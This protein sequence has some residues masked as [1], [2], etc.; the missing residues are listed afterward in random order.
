MTTPSISFYHPLSSQIINFTPGFSDA[1]TTRNLQTLFNRSLRGVKYRVKE[2]QLHKVEGLWDRIVYFFNR[3]AEQAKVKRVIGNALVAFN[4]L[5]SEQQDNEEH[6][7]AARSLFLR[8]GSLSSNVMDRFYFYSDNALSRYSMGAH[9][10]RVK[11]GEN[12]V[13]YND[14][15]LGSS[16]V[17]FDLGDPIANTNFAQLLTRKKRE[18]FQVSEGKL[19]KTRY[20]ILRDQERPVRE[21]VSNTLD[22]LE[23]YLQ[24]T[25]IT[26]VH[27]VALKHIFSSSSLSGM[28]R[29]VY[30]RG[31][32]A[33]GSKLEEILFEVFEFDRAEKTQCLANALKNYRTT[34]NKSEA[35][36][37]IETTFMRLSLDEFY[38]A[39]RLGLDLERVGDG[40][41]G[42]ARYAR[43][44]F[45]RK[46]LVVKPGDEGPHGV[47][48]P[49]WYA[50]IK[51]WFGSPRSCL[52]GNSEPQAEVDSYL[53]DRRLRIFQVPPT[54][55][56]Y[57]ASKRFNGA[58]YKECSVQ[59]FVDGCKTLGEYVNISP[60]M[61][62]FPRSYLRNRCNENREELLARIPQASAERVAMHNFG[63][64]DIDCHFENILVCEREI[65][66]PSIIERL[67]NDDDVADDEIDAFVEKFYSHSH[68]QTLL[69]AL[70]FSE[71]VL[72]DGE[73]KRIGFIKHDGGSSGPHRHPNSFFSTRFKHLFEVL[74]SF[75]ENFS[76]KARALL[77]EKHQVFAEFL[78]EKGTRE[79]RNIL[80]SGLFIRYWDDHVARQNFK[81]WLLETDQ[82]E[83][84][85][86]R[87]EV[88]RNLMIHCEIPP[89]KEEDY[90]GYFMYHLD[91]IHR[92]M[93]TRI[94]SWKVLQRY[95]TSEEPMRNLLQIRNRN[96]FEREL[97]GLDSS[98]IEE[99]LAVV[100]QRDVR[101]RNCS[102]QNDYFIGSDA[103]RDLGE[104]G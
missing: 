66:E 28:K 26:R 44:R 20:R 34:T 25:E 71:E 16:I 91:R 40:G 75:D 72:V 65:A 22:Q 6:R 74:P 58:D 68:N 64:E 21:A 4:T 102:L 9:T 89:G 104:N 18:R 86:K 36:A 78:L 101:E 3:T 82:Q 60:R 13:D 85:R 99:H 84:Q 46:L 100:K 69:K 2:G 33:E 8:I 73:R 29:E 67:F 80:E 96:D 93:E 7:L 35:K 42:G 103:L 94:D 81:Q 11:V 19:E 92:N 45:G 5:L 51:R 14:D 24:R 87:T 30:D 59:M 62:N 23:T 41:S 17:E 50:R 43:D 53:L 88:A 1:D 48:N 83:E 27:K 32:I 95:I 54:E 39:Q 63:I 57:L 31:A 47:N 52:R 97:S 12:F 70:L 15:T 56:T 77:T 37:N 49:Q 38:F 98:G 61:H 55:L 79:V 10:I 76:D 90:R